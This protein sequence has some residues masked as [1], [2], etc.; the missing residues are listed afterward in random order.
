MVSKGVT[1]GSFVSAEKQHALPVAG[2]GPRKYA[3]SDALLY[4]SN[5]ETSSMGR[6]GYKHHRRKQ[7]AMGSKS[8]T[9][10]SFVE[11]KQQ[12]RV[13]TVFGMERRNPTLSHTLR[14]SALSERC[15]C[16]GVSIHNTAENKP[17]CCLKVA[18]VTV[19]LR[20]NS[21]TSAPFL[22]WNVGIP[23]RPARYISYIPVHQ[24]MDRRG[25]KRHRCKQTGMASKV[26]PKI[27]LLRLRYPRMPPDN[28]KAHP[29]S[30]AERRN[31]GLSD[32]LHRLQ[33]PCTPPDG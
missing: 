4:I 17:R 18:S 31:P 26:A 10:D 20:L 5:P 30:R 21:N 25:F 8:G 33:S 3:R 1:D 7:T 11:A 9:D 22:A 15:H 32:A 2:V 27:V 16:I 12:H 13:L 6:R 28:R 24:P 29:V 19:L 23:P 14:T